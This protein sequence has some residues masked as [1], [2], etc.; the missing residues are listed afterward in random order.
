MSVN[1][2]K[3]DFS[4]HSF[5]FRY[6]SLN[7]LTIIE[8]FI[9]S[10]YSNAM[11]SCYSSPE[12]FSYRKKQKSRFSKMRSLCKDKRLSFVESGSLLLQRDT[13]ESLT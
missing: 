4:R 3:S 10:V 9:S 1:K 6:I 12:F 13:I 8:E 5:G 7:T 11:H 2:V